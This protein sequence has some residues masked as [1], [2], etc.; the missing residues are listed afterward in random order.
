MRLTARRQR[1]RGLR[2]KASVR[3]GGT[4]VLAPVRK[5]RRFR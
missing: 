3:F 4:T 1:V 2:Y 5:T